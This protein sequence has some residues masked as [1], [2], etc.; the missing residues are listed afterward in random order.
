VT[1]SL[2]EARIWLP[3]VPRP[4]LTDLRL[5]RVLV[6]SGKGG[7]G[8]VL[9]AGTVFARLAALLAP[10][11]DEIGPLLLRP[12]DDTGAGQEQSG[13]RPGGYLPQRSLHAGNVIAAPRS[14]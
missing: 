9:R 5:H 1:A 12:G 2:R 7:R 11:E 13:R 8:A 14:P 3:E 10:G 6:S 4:G